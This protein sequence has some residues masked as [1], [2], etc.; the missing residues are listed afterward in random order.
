M[1][2][3][4][5]IS[6]IRDALRLFPVVSLLGPR[7]CGKTTLARFFFGDGPAP[8]YFDLENPED[9]ARLSNPKL[10]LERL[11]GTVVIDEIQRSPDLFPILRVLVDRPDNQARFLILG[12][13]SRDLIKQSSESL[14]GRIH[15]LEISPFGLAEV[16]T[17]RFEQLW[18][19]GGFP[20]SFLA[21]SDKDSFTWL[22]AYIRTYLERD[23][24]QLGI[25]IPAT[26]LRRFWMMLTHNHSQIL[27]ISELGRSFGASETTIR[28]YIDVLVGTFMIRLLP[29]WHE[30]ISKRQVKRPKV[31]FR[32][33][34]VFH[35]LVGVSSHNDLQVS[36]KIGASWE[37]FAL[38]QVI[39]SVDA[40]PEE[41]YFWAVH[42]QA[43]LDLLIIKDG[44]RFGFEVK[45]EDAPR[46]SASMR[47]AMEILKLDSMTVVY[48]GSKQYPLADR[49]IAQPLTELVQERAATVAWRQS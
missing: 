9:L 40:S 21:N 25:Q 19:R 7:Q 10:A 6:A 33:S 1:E 8:N 16:G 38:E 48:P 30:N 46:L 36:P 18:I 12:S 27:N 22:E 29:P 41:T 24:P 47:A 37:G 43:E 42:E 23:I 44:K 3:T 39:K 45:Y 49:I 17:D 28:R 11:Q 14:A 13:A 31:F 15:Y 5:Y 34:G 32:D 2:R 20:L 35:R 4:R 26:Q